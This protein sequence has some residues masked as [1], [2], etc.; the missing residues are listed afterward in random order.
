MLQVG[1]CTSKPKVQFVIRD[2][3]LKNMTNI[4]HEKIKPN[5]KQ[6]SLRIRVFKCGFRLA[7]KIID[8]KISECDFYC[9][10][11]ISGTVCGC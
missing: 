8:T 11:L 4:K 10:R 7:Y 1:D 3:H 9:G 5:D 6:A 2:H